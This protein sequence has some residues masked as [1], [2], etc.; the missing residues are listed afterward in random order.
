MNADSFYDT[1]LA[2]IGHGGREKDRMR[3]DVAPPQIEAPVA[4]DVVI[5]PTPAIA[6]PSPPVVKTE[7]SRL[8]VVSRP[9]RTTLPADTPAV[10]AE[11]VETP[12]IGVGAASSRKNEPL[13]SS[14]SPPN[15]SLTQLEAELRARLLASTKKRKAQGA[16]RPPSLPPSKRPP[17]GSPVFTAVPLTSRSSGEE[18][19]PKQPN[20]PQSPVSPFVPAQETP[21]VSQPHG[22]LALPPKPPQRDGFKLRIKLPFAFAGSSS[23]TLET[24]KLPLTTPISAILDLFNR[25]SPLDHLYFA[26][27]SPRDEPHPEPT[28]SDADE[29]GVVGLG[30]AIDSG[31]RF[32]RDPPRN[33][34]VGGWRDPAPSRG[35]PNWD[36]GVGN[37]RATLED[38]ATVFGAEMVECE[39]R[40]DPRPKSSHRRGSGGGS[41]SA[42][43]DSKQ[44]DYYEEDDDEKWQEAKP[45]DEWVS[46]AVE[47]GQWDYNMYVAPGSWDAAMFTAMSI[48]MD[49]IPGIP[50]IAAY[51]QHRT[52]Q[53][54]DL[55]PAQR[56]IPGHQDYNDAGWR[57][58][59]GRNDHQES[60][61][62]TRSLPTHINPPTPVPSTATAGLTPP[63]PTGPRTSTIPS[64]V[65][66]RQPAT[67]NKKNKKRG[68]NAA[69]GGGGGRKKNKTPSGKRGVRGGGNGGGGNG[70]GSNAG[71]NGSASGGGGKSGGNSGGSTA[72]RSA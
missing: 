15:K 33:M 35:G 5:K 13:A 54:P 51:Q 64:H 40:C 6:R 17:R 37:L 11:S 7:G 59:F 38:V 12:A 43:V 1:L 71:G 16:S 49:W 18:A 46:P 67:E 72:I 65:P 41:G 29:E 58:G 68:G 22:K 63:I 57:F 61:L 9:P 66:P 19:L 25:R 70:G 34:G 14:A 24:D 23:I 60:S 48:P 36:P 21:T 10:K 4:G 26:P 44:A 28:R 52:P 2:S 55:E 27:P 53:E 31:Q 42:A 32:Y 39:I 50:G 45:E 69:R 8:D 30:I 47:Q 20:V 62:P 3:A 56:W